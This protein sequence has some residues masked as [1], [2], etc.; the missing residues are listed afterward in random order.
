MIR[1]KNRRSFKAEYQWYLEHIYHCLIKLP[2]ACHFNSNIKGRVS[3]STITRT[4]C[5]C[6]KRERHLATKKGNTGE[7]VVYLYMN[8]DL[9]AKIERDI[10][11]KPSF[12]IIASVW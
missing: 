3:G 1:K 8:L 5:D 7:M 9:L 2:P 6:Q 4:E 12:L 10:A 11:T